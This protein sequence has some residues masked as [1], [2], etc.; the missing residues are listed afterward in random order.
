MALPRARQQARAE[1]LLM[2]GLMFFA[3]LVVGGIVGVMAMALVGGK[4]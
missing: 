4:K 1:V 3:G 2:N